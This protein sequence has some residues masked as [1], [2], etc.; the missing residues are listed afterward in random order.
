MWLIIR[1]LEQQLA[2]RFLTSLMA[3]LVCFVLLIASGYRIPIH[4][5]SSD[6]KIA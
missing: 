1:K 3:I 6:L 5:G 2:K 4:S